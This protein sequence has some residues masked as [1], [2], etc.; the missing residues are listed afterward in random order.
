M[1]VHALSKT[2]NMLFMA[3]GGSLLR[4]EA[5]HYDAM[6]E[7]QIFNKRHTQKGTVP[8]Q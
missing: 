7:Y 3:A 6:S 4:R 8:F 1:R 5:R 2:V